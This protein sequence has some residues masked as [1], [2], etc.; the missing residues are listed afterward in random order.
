[1]STAIT[2]NSLSRF[3]EDLGKALDV[4]PFDFR[5]SQ[6]VTEDWIFERRPFSS[7]DN[8]K[9]TDTYKIT[10]CKVFVPKI[11]LPNLPPM[12]HLEINTNTLNRNRT[13][14]PKIKDRNV[15]GVTGYTGGA[16][17]PDELANYNYTVPI[18][19]N[20][21]SETDDYW[22]FES[23]STYALLGDWRRSELRI[24]LRD[25]CGF[26]LLPNGF[27]QQ[28]LCDFERDDVDD[29][30]RPLFQKDIQLIIILNA[31]YVENDAV[32]LQECF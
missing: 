22:I 30:Y 20:D 23:C 27:T 16:K 26:I 31:K 6:K 13:I 3:D 15:I 29:I 10:V 28:Q 9:L 19:V 7:S 25:P 12:L 21:K 11:W 18:Y 14:G 1:M 4:S 24:R 8:N 2:I 5:I 32:Y 17:Y